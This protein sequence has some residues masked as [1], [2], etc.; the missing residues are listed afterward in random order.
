MT[1]T[2]LALSLLSGNC[3]NRNRTIR[4]IVYILIF[5]LP[6]FVAFPQ[7]NSLITQ[8]MFNN[9]IF[10]PAFAGN[11]GGIC[12][13]GLAR[14][15]WLG[16]KDEDGNRI[17]PETFY[18]TVDA[19]IKVLHGGI[20]GSLSQDKLGYF[21]N[22][23]VKVGYAFKTDLGPG[24][25]SIGLQLCLQ[26]VRLDFSKFKPVDMDDE[27]I[28]GKEKESDMLFDL[29]AGL[30]YQIPDKFYVGL[31]S[32]QLLQSKGKNTYYKLRRHYYLTAGYQW[33]I[34][35]H[36]A[37]ELLPSLLFLYDGAAFQF[38]ISALLMYNNKVY[39]GLGYRLQDAVSILAGVNFKGFRIGVSYDI[40]TS[41]LTKYNSGS[42]ELMV[43]YCFKIDIDKFRRS[44]H[45]TRFL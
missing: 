30:F 28:M 6:G 11:S 1:L 17:A 16:F 18:L 10:N 37:F 14:E 43:S 45:N 24:D 22:I 33:A 23:N 25:L 12:I 41:S 42:V 34:P 35:N 31:S 36:P 3:R 13:T 44:Y 15:Q 4:H 20:G 26:S 38:N 2:V 9:M 39:G 8:Y 29:S 5:I 21:R 27:L 40:C 32:D 19:P 7:Q